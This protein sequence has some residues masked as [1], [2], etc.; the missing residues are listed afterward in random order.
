MR[1]DFSRV[2]LIARREWFQKIRQR[3]FIIA[4]VVQL[5]VVLALILAPP[6]ISKLFGDGGGS[7]ANTVIVLN[8][9]DRQGIA[10]DL[11][12]SMRNAGLGEQVRYQAGE[13]GA[14]PA[15]LLDDNADGVLS[16][17]RAGDGSLA[18]TYTNKDGAQD[19]TALLTQAAVGELALQDNLARLGISAEE[20]RQVRATH[21]TIAGVDSTA[22]SDDTE[23]G[24]RYGVAYVSA[25]VMYMAV[26]V[27]GLWVAQGVVEEKS[28]RI[29]E[30]MINAARPTELMFGKVVGIGLAGLTQLVPVLLIAG[31]GLFSQE[32][33]AD[34]L[35]VEGGNFAG[36]DF[37]ALSVKLVGFFLL[38]FLLGFL[39]YAALYAGIG[40]LVSRQEDVSTA[41]TPMTFAVVIGFFAAIYTLGAPDSLVARIVSIIPLTSPMTM[42][43]RVM[44]GDPKPWEIG[45]SVALLVVAVWLAV[46]LA[47][48]IYRMG[49]LMYGQRPSLKVIFKR[50]MITAAR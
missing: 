17:S 21:M 31:I 38:Y 45:L 49:V 8:K 12:A 13:A 36:I 44:L 42:V 35:G 20:A 16:V 4:T 9:S 22:S 28:S 18:F 39:L 26:M 27:Y 46:A 3:P 32:R 29:M 48:R 41:T 11:N 34:A 25:L 40:S 37:G 5:V 1:V 50:D 23:Q 43:P 24:F 6:V 30:I 47:A 2:W 15:K 10:D 33:L 7:S 14:D 19:Q